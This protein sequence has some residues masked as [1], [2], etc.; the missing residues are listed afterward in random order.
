MI[1]HNYIKKRLFTPGWDWSEYEFKRRCYGRWAA[2]EIIK[3]ISENPEIDPFIIILHFRHQMDAISS[4][5][6][7]SDAEFIF[8]TARDT[9]D[10]IISLF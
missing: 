8:I 3:R 6:E 5:R 4:L 9:A 2:Y 10:E 1:I 7:D